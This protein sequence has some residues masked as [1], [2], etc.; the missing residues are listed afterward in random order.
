MN[1]S[2]HEVLKMGL[3]LGIILA[4]VLMAMGVMLAQNATVQ[5]G[6]P[7]SVCG[8]KANYT[9]F[10]QNFYLCTNNYSVGSNLLNE[11]MTIY[12]PNMQNG[13]FW[14]SNHT[15]IANLCQW[16]PLYS[17][18]AENQ[19]E[20]RIICAE[21]DVLYEVRTGPDGNIQRI[22]WIGDGFLHSPLFGVFDLFV[23]RNQVW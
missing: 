23:N 4:L 1:K 5:I 14:P 16:G 7:V 21:P 19:T 22:D 20:Y 13:G 11:S 9:S 3:K 8:A 10:V 17:I 2:E 12:T 18:R 15:Q 6:F